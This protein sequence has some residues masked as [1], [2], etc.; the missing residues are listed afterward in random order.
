MAVSVTPIRDT[1]WLTLEVCREFQRGTCS[2]PDTECKFAHPSKSCQVENGRVIACF[3]SLKGRCS[4]ENCKYLHPPPHLK[5]QLEIN[6]RNNLI[7]QKNMAMLAQQM[8]LANAMMPGAPLQ[9]V[10]LM[11]QSF[12]KR[13]GDCISRWE[14]SPYYT[15]S[16]TNYQYCTVEPMF[17]VAPSL[18]TNASA[19]FNPYLGPVSPSLVPAEILPTAP[20]LVTGNP[21]VPV[22][23]AAAAAAQKLMRTDRLEV[24]REYQ[25]GNCNR[26]ENDCR[27]AHPAD[28]TMIDTNDNTVTVC[29]DY[30]KGRCSREKCK[31]FHPPAHLQAKIKAAQYQV[32]QAA[33]AQAAA[34][35]AAMG[36]PQAVLP[37]LPKRP[38]LEKTN[39]ATAVFNTGI[40]QYQQALANMQ[41]QQHTAFLPPGS[42]LCMTPATSVVPMVHGAT[43]ATVSAATTSATSVP[44]AATAT[45]N[46]IPIISAE[47]LTSHKYVTQM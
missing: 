31:Y 19:A 27:F 29:M 3:D 11:Q 30:I 22:P 41:L 36:I 39:G 23:A 5:T 20:M 6:G 26:G 38:A 7:Q 44:F 28:S 46:Q 12:Q 2:R 8:Q 35:A 24:C 17:S 21:G 34:T 45:A 43:P 4:R 40:F 1:K 18:A 15:G 37:P 32:N 47:H 33:A 13:G 14:G 25:R 16:D 10:N 42:I 9:P